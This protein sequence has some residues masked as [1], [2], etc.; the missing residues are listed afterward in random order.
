M[1]LGFQIINTALK[2]VIII[3][4]S[5]WGWTGKIACQVS[6]IYLQGNIYFKIEISDSVSYANYLIA[7]ECFPCMKIIPEISIPMSPNVLSERKTSNKT[8]SLKA[9]ISW[10]SS[11][12]SCQRF[13]EEPSGVEVRWNTGVQTVG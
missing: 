12:T 2:Y 1:F 7:K 9:V 11:S 3:I 10:L 6:R 8:L 13:T 5:Q 4:V